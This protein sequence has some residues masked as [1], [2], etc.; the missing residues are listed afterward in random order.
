MSD[1]HRE[2]DRM[3]WGRGR[4]CIVP[5][6]AK[7]AL[8][9]QSDS[10]VEHPAGGRTNTDSPPS[11]RETLRSK[12]NRASQSGGDRRA[13]GIFELSTTVGL[14]RTSAGVCTK[15]RAEIAYSG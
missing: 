2:R 12:K 15:T 6:R 11:D 14:R 13:R 7:I 8:P 5:W 3:F 10:R 4:S 9:N 1:F